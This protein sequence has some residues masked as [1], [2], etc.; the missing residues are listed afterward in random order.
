MCTSIV[1]RHLGFWSA[2]WRKFCQ[3]KW[4]HVIFAKLKN[5]ADSPKIEPFEVL[6]TILSVCIMKVTKQTA[7]KVSCQKIRPFSERLKVYESVFV[8]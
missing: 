1:D 2:I 8:T 7:K 5:I 6:S 3:I 4:F